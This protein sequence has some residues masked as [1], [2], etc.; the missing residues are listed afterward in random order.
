[1]ARKTA[2]KKMISTPTRVVFPPGG[3]TKYTFSG[4]RYW[5]PVCDLQLVFCLGR[6]AGPN[7]PS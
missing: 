2:K 6:I 1:M 4:L 5:R 7:N 3:L